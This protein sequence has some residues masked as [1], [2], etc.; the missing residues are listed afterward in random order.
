MMYRVGPI[1]ITLPP[2][3]ALGCSDGCPGCLNEFIYNQR[4]KKNLCRFIVFDDFPPS[5]SFCNFF[6]NIYGFVFREAANNHRC[7]GLLDEERK[8]GVICCRD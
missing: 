4:R 5:V 8:Q 3:T 6:N 1:S 7:G 2:Y